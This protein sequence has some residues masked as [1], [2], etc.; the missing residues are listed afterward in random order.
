[1]TYYR[2]HMPHWQ[3]GNAALFVTWRLY[4]SLPAGVIGKAF[5]ALDRELDS[6]ATGPLWLKDRIA[7]MV[8]DALRF[9]QDELKLYELIAY[10]VMANHVHVLIRPFV[11]LA[12]ITKT[13]KGFTARKGN[14]ALGRTGQPFGRRS[15]SITGFAMTVSSGRSCATLSATL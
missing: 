9:G 14:Q 4:G 11:A 2:I 15:P 3:P 1:M 13:I 8:V 10:V 7:A 5:A 6:A 12:R